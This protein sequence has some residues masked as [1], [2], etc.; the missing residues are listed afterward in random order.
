MKR[1]PFQ[2][3]ARW[4]SSCS[5]A[6]VRPFSSKLRRTPPARLPNNSTFSTTLSVIPYWLRAGLNPHMSPRK[7]E[8]RGAVAR[9]LNGPPRLGATIEASGVA[10][11]ALLGCSTNSGA[12]LGALGAAAGAAPAA[13]TGVST[14]SSDAAGDGT[15]GVVAAWAPAAQA[16]AAA[17]ANER[18]ARR[19]VPGERRETRSSPSR[20]NRN[21]PKSPSILERSATRS[22]VT[23]LG[24]CHRAESTNRDQIITLLISNFS[25][26]K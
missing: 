3:N 19:R 12:A 15:G 2:P 17:D 25:K 11:V 18:A 21:T 13:P 1:P 9:K 16:I 7:F 6:V 10:T 8:L 23:R 14:N 20:R 5:V 26:L 4:V 22:L 24:A